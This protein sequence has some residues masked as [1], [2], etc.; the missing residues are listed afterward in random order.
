MKG[1]DIIEKAVREE[2]PDMEQMRE[3]CV[4]QATQAYVTQSKFRFVHR[5][6]F[7][8]AVASILVLLIT[9]SAI[10]WEG[11]D[12][13][14]NSFSI[15]A[16]ATDDETNEVDRASAIEIA[17][18]AK[19]KMPNCK[20]SF[21]SITDFH[22]YDPSD[23]T[24]KYLGYEYNEKDGTVTYMFHDDLDFYLKN[25]ILG[26][27]MEE[28]I[29]SGTDGSVMLNCEGENIKSVSYT[30]A[31]GSINKL[32]EY[33]KLYGN[34]MGNEILDIGRNITID[35]GYESSEYAI[36]WLATMVYDFSENGAVTKETDLENYDYSQLPGDTI[37][38]EVE[39]TNGE[40]ETKTIDLSFDCDGYV[41]MSIKE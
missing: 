30:A 1:K 25:K 18:N 3:S 24:H 8:Y 40:K 26:Y 13:N 7:R 36:E 35:Y 39:F 10:V 14:K 34:T 21:I 27:N 32:S 29:V 11:D 41:V 38:I 31:S 4:R 23:P 9:A 16:Y 19:I 28:G 33:K 22:R 17:D 6:V 37:E 12:L 5:S 20:I 2:M 15:I